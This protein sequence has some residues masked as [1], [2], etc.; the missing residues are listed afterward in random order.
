MNC[1]VLTLQ[2]NLSQFRD[3]RQKRLLREQEEQRA[4]GTK[5]PDGA[6]LSFKEKMRLFAVEAGETTPKDK[7]K[8]SRAQ[9]DIEFERKVSMPAPMHGFGEEQLMEDEERLNMADRKTSAP[10][11]Y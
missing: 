1:T 3:P 6:K 11:P 7:T 5:Q 10:G 8:I 9:R 4:Q 2:L